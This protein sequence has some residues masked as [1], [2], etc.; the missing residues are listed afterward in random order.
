MAIGAQDKL[1]NP[2]GYE[3]GSDESDPY[4]QS[5]TLNRYILRTNNS[6]I[7]ALFEII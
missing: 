5:P 4:N 1:L 3:N 6:D 7:Y 2:M